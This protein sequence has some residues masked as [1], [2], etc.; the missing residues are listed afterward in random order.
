M[1]YAGT[2]LG[3]YVST[4]GAKS[5]NYLGAGLPNAPIWDIQIHTRDNML[6][7]A[8]NGRGMWVIYNAGPIQAAKQSHKFHEF[9]R[10]VR[11]HPHS[12]WPEEAPQ[13]GA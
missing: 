7:I 1:L 4:N 10:R 3:V 8:S 13:R 12:G 5:W 6:P 2:D 9:S 11:Y